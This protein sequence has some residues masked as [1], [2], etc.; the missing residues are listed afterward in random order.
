MPY[1]PGGSADI[2]SQ[3][4]TSVIAG[5]EAAKTDTATLQSQPRSRTEQ[6]LQ[7]GVS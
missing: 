2:A 6:V 3:I 7:S 4:R 1:T 5:N